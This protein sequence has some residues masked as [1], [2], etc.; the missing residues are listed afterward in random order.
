MSSQPSSSVS[1][2]EKFNGKSNFSLW[3]VK[4]RALLK[5]QGIWAP[6]AGPKPA[7]MSDAKF[8]SLD[9]KAH[10]TILLSLSDEVLYEVADEETAAG[11]WKKLEKLYMTKSLTNKLLLKQRLFSLRMKEG[12]ALKDHLDALN[13]ILMDLKNVDVKID[14]EDAAL[15]LLVSLPPSY[16]NFVNSF[17]VG[18]ET[19]TLE[20]VRS[21]LHSR[22]LR[23][24]ASG[25]SESQPVGLSI[26]SQDRGR[27]RTQRGK[28]KGRYK[29]RSKSRSRGSNPQDT[30]YYCHKEGHWKNQCPKLKEKGQ[31]AAVAKDDSGSERELVLSVVDYKGTPLAWIMDSACS[32]HMSPNRDWFVTYEEFDGGHVFMGNDS[33]CKV[34]GI[35]TIQIRMHDGVVRTLTDVRHVP[36]LKKN[37]ISLGVFDSKG[38]KYTSENGVLRVSK[39]ALVVMKATKGTSSLYTLQGETIT[40]SASV[41]CTEKSNSDLTKLWHMRLGHMS[42]KGMVILSKRGLLDNH[43]VAN[44]EF[45]EHCVM[46]KQKR[47][48]FSKAIHQTK[49]TLD[50]LH[51]DCWGPSRVPS[52]GGA[53]YFLSIIDDFSRMTWVFMMKHKSEAFEKFKH[54]K[55]LIENQTGR[56]IKR[57]RTDNGLEFCSREFEAFCR[58]E[59]IVR[60]YTVRYTPQQNGVAER[61]NRTLLER[62]RCLLLNA[63]LDRSFWA[64][65]LNTTCYLVNRSPATAIDCKT[66]I[67]VWTGKPADYSKLRVFGCPAYYHVSDGKLN[68]RAN[69][70]IFMGYGDGVKGYR[71]WSPSE[72]RVILS[73]DVT[74]DEDHLFRLKPDSVESKFE[75]GASEKVEHVAKQVEYVE[76]EVP[77]DTDHDVTSLD[78]PNSAHLEH[79]QYRSIALDRPRRD[80]KA[81]SRLGFQNYVAYAL[82]VAEEVESLEP[83]T[84]QEAITSKDS[85]MWSAAMGEEIESL[86]KNNTWALVKLPE[87][88][89]V[90]GCKWVFKKKTGLS[91]SDNIRF[92][93]RLV[94][95]GFSQKEGIDYNEIFSPVVRHT[96]IRVLLS[97]VA[98]H[99]LELEQLDVKTAFLH[100]D[101]EEEIYMSQPEGFVVQGKEDYVCKI[102]KSL[103][104]LKQSPKQWA[105]SGSLIY[106][107]LYVDDMLVAAKDMEEI[108]KLK[109]LLNTEFDMKDLGA[110]RK[111]LGMEIIRDRKHGKLFLSQKSYIEKI[112]SRFGM[113]SAKSVNTPFSANFRLSTAYAPQSE[114]EIEYMSRI[115]YASAVGSLMYVMVCTRPDIAHAMSVVSRYMAHPGKEHWN[116]VKRIFRY[117]KGTSDVG[118]I[119]GGEREY[120]V[121]GYSDS[122]Y[123]ADLDA[124]RS[125]TGYV[126]TIGSSVAAKEGI[127][128]KGLIEDLGFPQD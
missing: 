119:Y 59:G 1:V 65:A 106:L 66:P 73:R 49:G 45:C 121:A 17:V 97:L 7:D 64:E 6:L 126:F 104:G 114:A 111:I 100:G 125:L 36:D 3:R 113:S 48:S 56:K 128:L 110:A 116:A 60:H 118:L 30:C 95:K 44:L 62:T 120:L 43:K 29:D 78:P 80:A 41:S 46:G 88:R 15:I 102:R 28:G 13:S 75:E 112:I 96:S 21:G 33:P 16:E 124:R 22:E 18:K 68:P 34:V 99:D 67:E 86:H 117:L 53:R 42:E 123:A 79:E 94:A 101:L 25:I 71:I 26:T 54:W 40:S 35:G 108:K 14:D 8:N 127:W 74:F 4:V 105:P 98:H 122:D 57:L 11:V 19:I 37:L 12:S 52:L 91:G 107:L 10:S 82:Q 63:G 77:E 9:E 47:V 58:D 103:Y 51:A 20:D 39:G 109:I 76:H 87:G 27:H 5:Q 92:K 115:P 32:F 24:Q 38:F 89:K 70:G 93:A 55:I 84:Y 23:H 83:A 2:V 31:V 69:K 81:P 72:R 85:D 90:V 50:Y 61:M